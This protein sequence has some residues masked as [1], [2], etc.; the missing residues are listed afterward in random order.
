APEEL[1]MVLVATNTP[2]TIF[3]SVAC[4]V[5]DRIGA[6]KAGASDIQTGCTSSISSLAL[7]TAGVA[8]GLWENV[9][10]IGA[11]VLSRLVDWEDRNTCVL[12]GDGAGAA[13]VGPQRD[14]EGHMISSALRSD[15]SKA[16]LIIIPGGMSAS[17]M[18]VETV[19]DKQHLI[20]MKGNEV[21]KFVNRNL[22]PFLD[23]FCTD[24]GVEP[25]SVDTWIFHQANLRIMDAVLKRIGVSPQKMYVN[26]DRYG[27]TSAASVFLALHEALEEERIT[28]GQRVALTSFGSGMTYGAFL[29]EL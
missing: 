6:V 17:P 11:E 5:Q 4:R 22:P 13:V 28:K 10:V 25:E 1:D 8:S 18:T 21:F 7:A 23:T 20:K 19:A 15:G 2:D 12:F 26:L 29:L 24:S 9:L 14:G 27:N 16:D 3:P